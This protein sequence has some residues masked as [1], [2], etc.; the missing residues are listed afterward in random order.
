MFRRLGYVSALDE[1]L[2]EV[3]SRARRIADGGDPSELGVEIWALTMQGPF[4]DD[5]TCVALPLNSIFG[6]LT[7]EVDWPG[8]EAEIPAAE[9]Q[10]RLAAE[11]WLAFATDRRGV[12]RF[13][14]HWLFQVLGMKR[15]WVC[16]IGDDGRTRTL[17]FDGTATFE[18]GEPRLPD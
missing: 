15:P 17:R 1:F 2:D 18:E 9:A 11:D 14:D 4:D 12:D 16:H 7:D 10:I 6:D 5:V 13:L 8:H 3:T